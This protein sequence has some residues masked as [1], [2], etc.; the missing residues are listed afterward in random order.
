[1]YSFL[2]KL[3]F[4]SVLIFPEKLEFLNLLTDLVLASYNPVSYKK[5]CISSLYRQP[6]ASTAK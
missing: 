5:A 6:K 4:Y 2:D 3:I 1:M